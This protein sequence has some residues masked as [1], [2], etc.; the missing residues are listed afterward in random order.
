MLVHDGARPLVSPGA[1]RRRR[2]ATAEHGAA[3]P[4]VPVAETLKRIDGDRVGGTVDRTDLGSGADA[5]GRPA[6]ICCARRYRR[7][8][9]D[10][11][12]TFTDEAALLEACSIEVHVVPGDPSN[13]K[14]TLP[15]DLAA[16]ARRAR[17]RR[18]A[19]RTGIGHD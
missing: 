19:R 6:A 13:L 11:P 12:E 2:P 5:T 10:G 17:P 7:F 9:A 18:R 14:V 4:V 1:R 8:P 3:I 16:V 15:A